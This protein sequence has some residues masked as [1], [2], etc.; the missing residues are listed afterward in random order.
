VS[1]PRVGI[2]GA[3]RARQGLGPFVARDLVAA[4]AQV[5]CFAV[6]SER[7]IAPA[8]AEIERHA[9]VSPRG[10]ADVDRM[11]DGEALDAVAILSPAE[12]HAEHLWRAAERGLAA[13]CEKPLVWGTPDLAA[14]ASRIVAAFADR[15]L[16]LYENCQWPCALPDFARLHPG[17]L[18]APPLRFRMEL[19]PAAPGLGALRDSLPHPLS[20]L[21]TLLPGEAAIDGFRAAALAGPDPGLRIEFRY[22]SG[23]RSCDVAVVLWYSERRPRRAALEIDGRVAERVVAPETYQLSFA[24]SGR[25]VP[26]DDPLTILVDDFVARL[27]APDEADRRSRARDIE[28]RMRLLAELASAY[29]Q[30][31]SA[32]RAQ[33][34]R[35]EPQASEDQKGESEDHE[36]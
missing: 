18:A 12:S 3:R 1:G 15:K 35:S 4:G 20:L 2:I 24:A 10:Y 23:G 34:S 19:Q 27:R 14:D 9:G 13:L 30:Q 26:I 17:A 22:R 36:K 32:Q 28:E 16:L 6:T 21:Q 11:L 29:L 7:S 8:R 5:P 33:V 31:V 25:T